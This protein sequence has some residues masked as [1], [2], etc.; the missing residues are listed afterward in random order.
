MTPPAH[1][2]EFPF[3]AQHMGCPACERQGEIS[4]TTIEIQHPVIAG[5]IKQVDGAGDHEPID[6]R[7]HL[8]EISR[9][10]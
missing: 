10:E 6:H 9:Q 4:D 7:V 1:L 5:N 2:L 3:N 8:D